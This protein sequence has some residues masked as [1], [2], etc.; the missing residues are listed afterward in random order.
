MFGTLG[1]IVCTLEEKAVAVNAFGK[2]AGE[3]D[4]RAIKDGGEGGGAIFGVTCDCESENE[5]PPE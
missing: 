2:I 4:G 1:G 5:L 3:K